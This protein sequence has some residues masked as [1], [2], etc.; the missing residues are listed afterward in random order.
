MQIN[1]KVLRVLKTEAISADELKH[2]LDKA[3]FTSI[4][5]CNRRFFQWLFLVK[6]NVIHDMQRL[7]LVEV[8]RGE[9]R[10]LEEHESC[11]GEGCRSCG[12]AGHVSRAIEDTTA[13]AM[14]AAR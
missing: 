7:D 9:N 6:D 14:N 5:G 12:W 3:A 8:G 11:N 4:R 13:H 2:M 1:N 10:M